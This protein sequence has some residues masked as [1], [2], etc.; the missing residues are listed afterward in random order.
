MK[1]VYGGAIMSNKQPIF[2]TF[3]ILKGGVGKT[4]IAYNFMN[5]LA[6]EK[7]EKVLAI[8]L[9]ENCHLSHICDV[10][11]TSDTHQTVANVLLGHDDEMTF[12]N[13]RDNVDL[14]AGFKN[15]NILQEKIA[16]REQKTMML[17]MW[18]EDN[19]ER[20]DLDQYDYIVIDTHN[21]FGTATKN[22]IAVSH[23]VFS[24]VEPTILGDFIPF[25]E[26]LE[27][28]KN[29]VI[30]YRT[31][32]SYITAEHKM[33]GNLYDNRT[34]NDKAFL[35]FM[36]T[37]ED[38]IAQFPRLDIFKKSIQKKTPISE[39]FQSNLISH[40]Q[41]QYKNEFDENMNNIY[42][43]TQKYV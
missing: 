9:D 3:S 23:V 26:E 11:E 34:K 36:E 12:H 17:Y 21:D 33:I 13:V 19:Y 35:A 43:E 7:K 1:L 8:D 2:V 20:Y 41:K 18:L 4:N 6:I 24:P 38:F 28:F 39:L 37:H 22:A 25:Q 29:Q 42:K 14:I 32:E 31:R 27:E 30:D 16:T 10:Y 40:S 15:L 5:W